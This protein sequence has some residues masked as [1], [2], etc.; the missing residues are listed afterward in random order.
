[1]S[2]NPQ[3]QA[4]LDAN[5]HIRQIMNDPVLLLLPFQLSSTH[6]RIL[7]DFLFIEIIYYF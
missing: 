6:Y 7:I 3:M 4:M 2:A 5:P 1:M